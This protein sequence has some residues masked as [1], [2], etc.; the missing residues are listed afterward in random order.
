[1]VRPLWSDRILVGWGEWCKQGVAR[2]LST[3]GVSRWTPGRARFSLFSK[4]H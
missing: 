1:M 4:Q 3:G 2:E